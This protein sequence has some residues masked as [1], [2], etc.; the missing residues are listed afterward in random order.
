MIA[1]TVFVYPDIFRAA[2]QL[3]ETEFVAIQT[4][5]RNDLKVSDRLSGQLESGKL[6]WLFN[7]TMRKLIYVQVLGRFSTIDSA[8]LAT[9]SKANIK[10]YTCVSGSVA[11]LANL[12][13]IPR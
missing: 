1:T 13:R 4:R 9:T 6:N 12:R 3:T 5:G 7:L 11:R 10:A 2:L 8:R